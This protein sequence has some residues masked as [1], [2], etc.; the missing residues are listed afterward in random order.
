MLVFLSGPDSRWGLALWE[1]GLA[2]IFIHFCLALNEESTSGTD[3][4][5]GHSLAIIRGGDVDLMVNK[6]LWD[7]EGWIPP[8]GDEDCLKSQMKYCPELRAPVKGIGPGSLLSAFLSAL[9]FTSSVGPPADTRWSGLAEQ[10]GCLTLE[11]TWI[12]PQSGASS[13]PKEGII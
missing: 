7:V 6:Y 10:E 11:Y 2:V 1:A 13:L 5:W 4:D 3:D 9:L 8:S 12:L